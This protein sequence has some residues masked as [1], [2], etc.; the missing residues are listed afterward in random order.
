MTL[1]CYR[2]TGVELRRL[3]ESS[4]EVEFFECPVCQRHY[5]RKPGGSLTYRWLHPVTLALYGVIFDEDPLSRAVSE[6][7]AFSAT[8]SAA[9][10]RQIVEEIE[11]ELDEPTHNVREPL[12]N[13]A[14]EEKC[15]EYLRAFA[16]RIRTRL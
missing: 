8:R 5:A 7:D 16:D 12:D 6:A 4:T 1:T 10:L 14:T 15:R 9:D 11:L 13:R 2:C 3:P